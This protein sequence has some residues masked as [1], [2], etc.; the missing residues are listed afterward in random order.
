MA[1]TTP[2]ERKTVTPE[3]S[4][5]YLFMSPVNEETCRDLI[6]FVIAKNLENPKAKYLQLLIS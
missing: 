2:E 4:N 3:D 1:K 5:I 6:S